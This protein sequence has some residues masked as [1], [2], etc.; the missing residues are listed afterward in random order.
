MMSIYSGRA[1]GLH[2]EVGE[3]VTPT[4]LK[5]WDF[6]VIKIPERGQPVSEMVTKNI[7]NAYDAG[8]PC[9]FMFFNDP[10]GYGYP[11]MGGITKW[12]KFGDD[13]IMAVL[14]R[15]LY[16]GSTKR[17]VHGI[18]ID[19]SADKLDTSWTA[20]HGA[21]IINMCHDNFGLPVFMYM[22]ITPYRNCKTQ[23]DVEILHTYAR[24]YGL[25]MPSR[26][27]VLENGIPADSESPKSN[28]D[29]WMLQ[30]WLYYSMDKPWRWLYHYDKATL[31]SKLGFTS[32][33]TPPVEPPEETPV[34]RAELDALYKALED[35]KAYTDENFNQFAEYIAWLKECPR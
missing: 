3:E 30:F 15:Y 27:D 14:R 25:S 17:K 24:E 13:P 26:A 34:T 19:S 20:D 31:Y 12:P 23:A 6:L 8:V 9:L 16:S 22:N 10:Q 18:I 21:H 7:Q 28:Y 32:T 2:A 29:G 33:T 5:G 4:M 1:K 35:Y 11:D